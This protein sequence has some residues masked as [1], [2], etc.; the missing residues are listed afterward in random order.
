MTKK[1]WQETEEFGFS[2][3]F[4]CWD[5]EL[6]DFIYPSHWHDYYEIFV[7]LQGKVS[8]IIDGDVWDVDTGDIVL[9]DPGR[10][11]SFSASA[12]KTCIRFFHFAQ[13]FFAK[14]DHMLAL[15]DYRSVFIQ[16]PIIHTALHAQKVD[17]EMFLHKNI[18]AF[19]DLLFDE[20]KK[21]RK[22]WQIA[23]KGELYR[24]FLTYVRNSTL[25]K[26]DKLSQKPFSANTEN[27]F[28]RVFLFINKNFHNANLDLNYAAQE[29]ALS[30]FHFSRFFKQRTGQS[31][32][33]YLSS[34][35]LGHAK[36]MLLKTDL[37]VIDI[38][39]NCGFSSL[40]TFFRVFKTGTGSTPSQYR[41]EKSKE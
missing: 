21:K 23:I 6:M 19:L 32:Y 14:E 13:S 7:V 39:R 40:S 15:V 33:A 12:P 24:L 18:S 9:L 25:D 17:V 31:F 8:I 5:T 37:P 2:F 1:P 10:L 3:P 4:R 22:G 38:A 36:A 28:E 30:R 16:K 41:K 27:R 20:Y 29:A 26:N 34:L 35:R 11:H